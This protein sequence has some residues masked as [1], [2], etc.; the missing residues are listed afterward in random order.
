[1]K[2]KIDSLESEQLLLEI[3][4]EFHAAELYELFC[5]IDLYHYMKRDVPPSTKWLAN[6]FKTLES[7][8]SPDGQ[9]FWLGWV[10]REKSSLRPVGV[11]E[12]SI[13]GDD[14]FITY[15]VFKDYWGKGYAVEASQ[16]MIE[17]IVKNYPIKKFIIEMDTRNRASTKVAEKLGFDF[18]KVVNNACFLKNF[19]SHE[20]QFQKLV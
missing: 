15:T 8:C 19:V 12:I 18:V 1:M 7:C 14:A 16:S 20:F 10:G 13:V 9:E 6:G 4:R 5:D 17:F 2:P 3:R 11:F